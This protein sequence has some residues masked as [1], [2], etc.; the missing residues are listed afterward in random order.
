[1][2]RFTFL[3][4]LLTIFCVPA[5]AE[6]SVTNA[7]VRL[8]PPGVPNT[9]AYFTVTNNGESDRFIV[10]ASSGVVNKVELHTH[11]M[12]NDMM[13]MRQIP[14]VK[15]AAGETVTF[16]SGGLHL[17]MFGLKQALKEQQEV[18]IELKLKDGESMDFNAVV[19]TPQA[20][21]HHHHH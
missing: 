6:L 13:M 12:E 18:R 15:V 4:L 20:Q 3:S 5:W 1:M 2:K 14:E 10:A 16:A 9:S 19:K 11:L 7:S 8:L 17:M 21:T